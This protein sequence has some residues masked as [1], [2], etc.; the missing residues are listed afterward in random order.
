MNVRMRSIPLLMVISSTLLAGEDFASRLQD[1]IKLRD[2]AVSKVSK[3]KPTASPDQ[4]SK[5]EAEVANRIREAR[6]HAPQGNIFTREIA[7]QFRQLIAETMTG[8]E[9]V[10][11]RQ[12]L[13]RSEPVQL[14]ALSVNQEYP[15]GV[16]LQTTPP[17]LL[18][19]LP[20]LPKGFEY[21]LVGSAILL[22]DVEANL[23]VDYI[24]SAIPQ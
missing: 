17:S 23:I 18:A 1:Y 22:L 11:I 9:A 20:R 12:S 16:P 10:T 24:P 8:K 4:I 6:E 2:R 7:A 21:R 13:A 3:L 14:R 5:H 15:K 19:N